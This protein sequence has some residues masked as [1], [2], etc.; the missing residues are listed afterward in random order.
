MLQVDLVMQK[1]WCC[2]VSNLR[3][4]IEIQQY[5][6]ANLQG[7]FGEI[8]RRS[9]LPCLY[10]EVK[11]IYM[12][13]DQSHTHNP[14]Q[15]ENLWGS[16]RVIANTQ[17]RMSPQEAAYTGNTWKRFGAW[18]SDIFRRKKKT[19]CRLHRKT[20]A[21]STSRNCV[22]ACAISRVLTRRGLS[23]LSWLSMVRETTRNPLAICKVAAALD[24]LWRC[25]WKKRFPYWIQPNTS[26]A[27]IHQ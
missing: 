11:I 3:C 25:V 20:C 21:I 14:S 24:A 2:L 13:K 9:F 4:Q 1:P 22:N 12:G 6:A 27:I 23:R 15:K 17:L 7:I 10:L 8:A 19:I 18:H 26:Y 16:L 5:G